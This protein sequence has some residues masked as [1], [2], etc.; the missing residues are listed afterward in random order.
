LEVI[1][2]HRGLCSHTV[3]QSKGIGKYLLL[4][5]TNNGPWFVVVK[6]PKNNILFA[7]NEFH[8]VDS[9]KASI[10]ASG[11]HF[12]DEDIRWIADLYPQGQLQ[13]LKNGK[14]EGRFD[15]KIRHSPTIAR[16]TK[17]FRTKIR[18]GLLSYLI[19]LHGR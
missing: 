17:L 13:L 3:D 9:S 10:V 5:V 15:M 12:A 18:K 4:K 7:S 16:G 1:G 11:S 19:V 2:Q 6:D 14:L 8:D